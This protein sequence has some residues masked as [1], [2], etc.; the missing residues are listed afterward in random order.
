MTFITF[1]M[2]WYS[3]SNLV[4][5]VEPNPYIKVTKCPSVCLYLKILKIAG[6]IGFFLKEKLLIGPGKV[7]NFLGG[8]CIEE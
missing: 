8:G 1:T 4:K 6:P 7:Y 5:S 3:Y 2:V